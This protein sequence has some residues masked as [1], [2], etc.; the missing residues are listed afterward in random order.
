M[1]D[2]P[3]TEEKV[4]H[5]RKCDKSEVDI[6]LCYDTF[7]DASKPPLVLIMGLNGQMV[8]WD[9]AV[10]EALAK[11]GF[12]VIRF[13][14]RD[15]GNST[16]VEKAAPD[17]LSHALP[18]WLQWWKTPEPYT[19]NCMAKDLWALVDKVCGATAKVHLF[20]IS[21]GG[22]IA[23]CATLLQPTRVASL[24]S[25]MSTTGAPDLPDPSIW[26]KLELTKKPKSLSVEDRTEF[27]LGLMRKVLAKDC[28]LDEEQVRR[29]SKIVAE[30]S[31]YIKGFPRHV[32]AIMRA[33]N[34][35]PLFRE[36]GDKAPPTLVLHGAKDILV[37]PACG[38][39]TAE[40]VHNAKHIEYADA[41]H[42]IDS[43]YLDELVADV[44][45]FSLSNGAAPSLLKKK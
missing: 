27:R 14:N 29:N 41:G 32:A 39:R 1:T 6:H 22:M 30:R 33:P 43:S 34:R 35:D 31:T 5:V 23:Q 9:E 16:K 7:G 40:V 18:W 8:M 44:A 38:R 45:G 10:C 12:Y 21:M 37:L 24:V 20:G 26:T 19:L 11:A 17:P 42:H 3:R 15:T 4:V 2:V 25:M 36:L 28:P 13:D